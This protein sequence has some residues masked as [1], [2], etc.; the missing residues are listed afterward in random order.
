[1][2]RLKELEKRLRDEPDNLGLRVA[3]AG[4]FVEADRR[5]DAVELYRSVAI[6]YRAQGRTHQ[7]ITVCR[8]VL[9]L[10][11]HDA[12]SQALLTAM[13]AEA[14]EAEAHAPAPPAPPAP[15]TAESSSTSLPT[16]AATARWLRSASGARKSFVRA[17]FLN[18]IQTQASTARSSSSG[19]NSPS[20]V[21]TPRWCSAVPGA[22]SAN[23]ASA[24][25]RRPR[26]R[27]TTTP[28]EWTSSSSLLAK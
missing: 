14:A 3:L 12:S 4:A 18:A 19:R 8:S 25:A 2:T 5:D 17:A 13:L 24:A 10:A 6:A 28:N 21:K 7:A 11:P 16:M 26:I 23:R 27:S 20:R 22:N 9:E 1:V 15:P